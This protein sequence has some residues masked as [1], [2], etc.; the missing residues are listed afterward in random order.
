MRT[1][2]IFRVV[3]LNENLHDRIAV[4]E[5]SILGKCNVENVL[6]MSVL[7]KTLIVLIKYKL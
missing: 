2:I 6:E 1:L 4:F 5:G 7:L 3:N